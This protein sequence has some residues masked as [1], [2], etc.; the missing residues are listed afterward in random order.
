MKKESYMN[1]IWH[2]YW[3]GGCDGIPKSWKRLPLDNLTLRLHS[4]LPVSHFNARKRH[5]TPACLINFK[6]GGISRIYIYIY[7]IWRLTPPFVC[8]CCAAAGDCHAQYCGW[9]G[10]RWTHA[11]HTLSHF[12]I[13]HLHLSPCLILILHAFN[14]LL[15]GEWWMVMMTVLE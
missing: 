11:S 2:A 4:Q 7:I 13:S 5:T 9:W 12:S 6:R 14:F 15:F 8:G 3:N 1:M 10:C